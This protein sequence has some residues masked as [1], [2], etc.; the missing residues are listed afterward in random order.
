LTGEPAGTLPGAYNGACGKRYDD[1]DERWCAV[2]VRTE[3]GT[4]APT[5]PRSAA[6]AR[7]VTADS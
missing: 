7:E 2:T 5:A 4:R 1:K 6:C 3:P